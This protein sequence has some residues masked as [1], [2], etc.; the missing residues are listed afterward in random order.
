VRFWKEFKFGRRVETR[1]IEHAADGWKF[2]TYV[3]NE[4]ETE[5]VLAPDQGIAATVPIRGEIRHAIPS[6]IDCRACHEAGAVPILGFG[7]LQLSPDRDP[8]APHAERLPEGAVDLRALV[9][10][11]LLRGLPPQFVNTPPRIEARTPDA[12]AALGYLHANCGICH[13]PFGSMASLGMSLTYLL[14]RRPGEPP[15]A[16]W[17]AVGQPS[18]FRLPDVMDVDAEQRI[19]PGDPDGSVLIGRVSSRQP[20][21]QMPPLGTK[22]VDDEA[23]ELLRRWITN[24]L[25]ARA[26]AFRKEEKK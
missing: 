4:N 25:P 6:Q 10:R 2:A 13:N 9:E 20:L 5:A 14:A 23:V 22:L 26:A 11:G 17:T 8:N 15:G 16:I 1:F 19:S 7:A 24:D 3:W 21:L 12:R 18:H